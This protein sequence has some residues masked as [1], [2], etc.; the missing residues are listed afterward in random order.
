MIE[1]ERVARA[2]RVPGKA[3]IVGCCLVV[4]GIVDAA[5]G[6]SGPKRAALCRVVIDH[7]E[8]DLDLRGMQGLDR[9]LQ[10]MQ[11]TAVNIAWLGREKSEGRVSPI[12]AQTTFLKEP[13]IGERMDRHQLDSRDA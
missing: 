1:I 6:Q 9:G 12:I 10:F 2:R 5:K 11:A 13:V 4:G 8:D 7:V 3:L